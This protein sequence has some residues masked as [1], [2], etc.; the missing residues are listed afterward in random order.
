MIQELLTKGNDKVEKCTIL[1][2]NPYSFCVPKVS[3]STT[4]NR[5]ESKLVGFPILVYTIRNHTNRLP[6]SIW[7]F[8]CFIR[9]SNATIKCKNNPIIYSQLL[10][11]YKRK[12]KKEILQLSREI[13]M[14]KKLTLSGE[15]H[16]PGLSWS[17]VSSNLGV[18]ET[19]S[20]VRILGS[21][22]VNNHTLIVFLRNLLYFCRSLCSDLSFNGN[23]FPAN[24]DV[25]R[26]QETL[27]K[28]NPC[29]KFQKKQKKN[30]NP[31]KNI[32]FPSIFKHALLKLILS[33]ETII[34]FLMGR[35]D[36]FDD[37]R[38]TAALTAVAMIFWR[39]KRKRAEFLWGCED[40]KK[41]KK[42]KKKET[43]S[44]KWQKQFWVDYRMGGEDWWTITLVV[45]VGE[46]QIL[47]R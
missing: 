23:Y 31:E 5:V 40:R 30:K 32:K 39:R 37:G 28:Q 20:D 22:L 19:F 11:N 17:I 26:V 38:E 12:K 4:G 18:E 3:K 1:W 47:W 44:E 43:K 41:K 14:V 16:V 6:L 46:L 13:G 25:S 15:Y 29:R 42:I 34:W 36:D 21:E 2:T 8:P 10:K 45:K 7:D 33:G 9:L 24:T 35:E 27:Q